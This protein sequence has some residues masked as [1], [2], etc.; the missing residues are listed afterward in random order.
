M[1]AFFGTR[2]RPSTLVVLLL[3]A[4][5]LIALCATG[6]MLWH[7][8]LFYRGEVGNPAAFF[9]PELSTT[10]VTTH[11]L[12][13][14]LLVLFSGG[15]A[16]AFL[17]IVPLWVMEMIAV[18]IPPPPLNGV[19]ARSGSAGARSAE[20]AETAQEARGDISAK[21]QKRDAAFLHKG[22]K[23]QWDPYVSTLFLFALPMCPL[24]VPAFI[25]LLVQFNM[26]LL[27]ANGVA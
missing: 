19:F 3:G 10:T 9:Y 12:R 2:A 22:K 4:L 16:Y 14:S 7:I 18:V 1:N 21:L 25:V 27:R 13:K 5:S 11:D 20:A 15:M 24:F 6:Y 26:N 8:V 17:S 23:R